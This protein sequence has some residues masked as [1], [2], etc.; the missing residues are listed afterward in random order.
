MIGDMLDRSHPLAAGLHWW[1]HGL[2]RF[3][4][5]RTSA[6]AVAGE[7]VCREVVSGK[8]CTSQVASPIVTDTPAGERWGFRDANTAAGI[9]V[10]PIPYTTGSGGGYT[11]AA[12]FTAKSNAVNYASII[13]TNPTS[14]P[15]PTL[16][17]SGG[18][19]RPLTL[20][21]NSNSTEWNAA[22]GLTIPTD[23]SVCM[24]ALAIDIGGNRTV[25]LFTQSAPH[26]NSF[27]ISST[28]STSGVI[29]TN[30]AIGTFPNGG[31]FAWDGSVGPAW[32]WKWKLSVDQLRSLY[33]NPW[34]MAR[35]HLPRVFSVPAGP[36]ATPWLYA[37]RSAQIIGA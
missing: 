9:Y 26:G 18:V 16:Q 32:A 21:W 34:Q 33:Q 19:G 36:T 22:T 6:S 37:R 8:A 13:G 24:A 27:T 4:L 25:Y 15:S 5:R 30:T 3:G 28:A 20:Q 12:I 2:P 10:N 7:Y 1:F 14:T 11:M 35:R 29:P 23:G 31:A 17:A